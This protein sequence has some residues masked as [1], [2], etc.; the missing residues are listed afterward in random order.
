M[1]HHPELFDNTA[2]TTL[3]RNSIFWAA[4]QPATH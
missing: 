1:G 4:N 3:F 2:F